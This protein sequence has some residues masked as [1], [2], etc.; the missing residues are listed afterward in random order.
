MEDPAPYGTAHLEVELPGFT[1]HSPLF[2]GA[3]AII[4]MAVLYHVEPEAFESIAI[5]MSKFGRDKLRFMAQ[6]KT[7]VHE[8][9]NRLAHRF[10][11]TDAEYLIFIDADMVIPCGNATYFN[12]RCMVQ[13]PDHIAGMNALER[14]LSHPSSMGIVGAS[15]FDRQ[16][17]KQLQCS[18]GCG[19]YAEAGFNDR[20]RRG[21][22]TGVGEVLWTATGGMRIHRRVFEAILEQKEKFPEAIPVKGKIFGFF[23]P[24]RVGL[25]EDVA[26]CAR[27]RMAGFKIWQDY[28]LRFLHKGRIF[29]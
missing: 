12:K 24:H 4:C 19:N 23:T 13:L 1:E 28:D 21:D 22:I 7:V 14:L 11:E 9:R 29:H 26:M 5:A 8:S 2:D 18:R 20:Y 10:L 25:G 27:A 17:G 16:V 6:E 15:Y 3:Q